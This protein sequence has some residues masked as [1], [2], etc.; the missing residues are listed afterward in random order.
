MAELIRELDELGWPPGR[1]PDVMFGGIG[2]SHL[3]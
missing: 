3:P 1:A 2:S